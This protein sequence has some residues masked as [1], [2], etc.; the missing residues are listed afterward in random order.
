MLIL[1]L[2]VTRMKEDWDWIGNDNNP[3]GKV[4]HG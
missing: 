4:L 1:Q 2:V 3:I